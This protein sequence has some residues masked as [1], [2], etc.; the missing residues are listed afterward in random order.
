MNEPYP[1]LYF[2]KIHK[3]TGVSFEDHFSGKNCPGWYQT[4]FAELKV[5]AQARINHWN[6]MAIAMGSDWRY[7][8]LDWR[9]SND[10]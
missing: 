7:E 4:P 1:Y 9:L 6:S 2:R 8:I 5:K 3:E 10:C